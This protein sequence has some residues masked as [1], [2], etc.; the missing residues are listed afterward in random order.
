MR[1]V[2]VKVIRKE[3]LADAEVLSRFR[4]E[5]ESISRLDHPNVVRAYDAGPLGSVYGLVMEYVDGTDLGRLVR[6]EGPLP[7]AHACEFIRQAAVG[8]QYIHEQG[9]V[10]R[11]IKPPNLIL[12]IADTGLRTEDRPASPRPAEGASQSAIRNPQSAIIKIL[13]LGLARLPRGVRSPVTNLVTP[14]GAV[15]MGTPDYLAPE[16]ALDFHAA[17]IRSDIYGLGSTLFYLLT[18]RPPFAGGTMAEKLLRHQQAEPPSL[19]D[20]PPPVR[21]TDNFGRRV[22]LLLLLR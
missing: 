15:M 14:T 4:R 16:Q 22:E 13:D 7:A 1:L 11:D 8:L 3:L 5:V 19:E 10:H 18:G 12:R 2:A 20:F 17:D 6:Q 21:T 9:L